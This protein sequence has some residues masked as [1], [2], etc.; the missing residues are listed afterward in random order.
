[1]DGVKEVL[2]IPRE[3]IEPSPGFEEADMERFVSSIGKSGDTL[4][5]LID[6]D[7]FIREKDI[8]GII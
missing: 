5:I 4:K 2:K 7:K 3:A 1:M 8:K 6:L